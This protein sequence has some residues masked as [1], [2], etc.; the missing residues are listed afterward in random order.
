MTDNQQAF[1]EAEKELQKEKIDEIKRIMKSVLQ[2]IQNEKE[3][4]EES[5]NN[6]RLLKMDL[7][8]LRT[9]KIDRIKERHE[10]SKKA[11]EISPIKDNQLNILSSQLN[12]LALVYNPSLGILGGN[13]SVSG[14]NNVA[15]WSTI[16]S[17]TYMVDCSNGTVKEF[18]F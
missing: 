14:E 13:I 8:D 6:L 9:G 1:K 11:A 2:K 16:T 12:T 17:G 3:R 18:N 15:Y 4:K 10:K 7:E 5:E